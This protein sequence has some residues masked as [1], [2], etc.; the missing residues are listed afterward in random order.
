MT[1]TLQVNLSKRAY[2]GLLVAAGK[3]QLDPTELGKD[4]LENSGISY[5]NLNRVG[6]ITSAELI[7]RLAPELNVILNQIET[8]P[9]LKRLV[10]ILAH[11]E[12]LIPLDSPDLLDGL[13][14]LAELGLVAPARIVQ[15]LDYDQQPGEP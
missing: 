11:R 15:I 7:L 9:E 12:D 13:N 1:Y 10:D 3:M 2:Y 8:V 14:T 4:I 5:A 6:L